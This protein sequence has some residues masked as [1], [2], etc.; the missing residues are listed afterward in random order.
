MGTRHRGS[1]TR[2]RNF[3]MNWGEIN[4]RGQIV[5]YSE[6]EA[7]DPNGEDVC[8]FGWIEALC[9]RKDNADQVTFASILEWP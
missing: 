3:F 8:G 4:D 2:L 1:R 9:E 6:T 7:L 5:G